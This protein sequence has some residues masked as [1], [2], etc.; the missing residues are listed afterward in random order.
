[1]KLNVKAKLLGGFLTVVALMA[2]MLIVVYVSIQG[3]ARASDRLL[4]REYPVA[5]HAMNLMIHARNEQQ[6]LTDLALTGDSASREEIKTVSQAFDEELKALRHLEKGK[7]LALLD[8]I[9]SDEQSF[10]QVG[11]TMVDLY[12]AGDKLAGD[13]Q[14]KKFDAAADEFIGSLASIESAA[15]ASMEAAMGEMDKD[16]A[17]AEKTSMGIGLLAGLIAIVFGLYL[18]LTISRA[19]TAV[20]RAA[21][22]LA[23]GDLDQDVEVKSKDELGDMAAAFRQSIGYMHEMANV[24][25]RLA[26]GDLT[27]NVQPKSEKDV[28]GVAFS[29]MVIALRK[30]VA[31]VQ[32]SAEGLG[33]T[34]QQLSAAAEQAAEATQQVAGTIQQ[35]AAGT[36]QQAEAATRVTQSVDQMTQ[37]IDGVAKG[38]Q[39][40]AA[41]AE[42]SSEVT[43]QIYAAI[44][45]TAENAQLGSQV[46]AEAAEAARMGTHTVEETVEGMANIKAK[47]GLSAEKVKEMGERSEQIGAI[48]E[49]I[50]DIASQTNLLALNAAIEAARAGEHGKGFAVVADEVRKLAEKA[51]EAT[52]EIAELI[53]GTQRTVADAMAAMEEGAE[54]VE[55]RVTRANKAGQDRA[56]ST[57]AAGEVRQAEAGRGGV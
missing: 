7:D 48:V 9:A 16:Q 43:A 47:V 50:D 40:Q 37:A 11:Y 53:K 10:L 49:T 57:Q 2:V 4:Y 20:A 18:S 31:Q 54:E 25:N 38:A 13:A 52:K 8:E 44:E 35:V 56:S 28:L 17:T 36:A 29:Q 24:A 5:D 3:I 34:S 1:M 21:E 41:A 15:S 14:M 45:Q 32:Q 19:V 33:A 42:R 12:Q 51:T 46:A 26:R 30:M 27:V 39:D 55:A 6:L 23:V 22:G